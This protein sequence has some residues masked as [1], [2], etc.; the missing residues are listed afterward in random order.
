[1]K[2]FLVGLIMFVLLFAGVAFANEELYFYTPKALPR[3]AEVYFN[4]TS[5]KPPYDT[6]IIQENAILDGGWIVRTRGDVIEEIT[7]CGKVS[8]PALKVKDIPLSIRYQQFSF[9]TS[10]VL[11]SS[12]KNLEI[13]FTDYLIG[14]GYA[15]S[16]GIGNRW[17]TLAVLTAM[18]S[19]VGTLTDHGLVGMKLCAHATAGFK[20]DRIFSYDALFGT[21]I[22]AV[23]VESE[24]P[25]CCKDGVITIRTPD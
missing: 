4:Y 18:H 25:V 3:A 8:I 11:E 19:G 6:R 24:Y 10:E 16:C 20:D 12:K 23:L 14:T 9:L 22:N 7:A 15:E 17:N 1:M 2:K 21:Q 13:K 5:E